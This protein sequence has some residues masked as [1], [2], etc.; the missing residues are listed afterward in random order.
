MLGLGSRFKN[1]GFL[2]P[3]YLLNLAEE[4]IL[5][6]VLYGF[7]KLNKNKFI[8]LIRFDHTK[9]SPEKEIK[10]ICEILKIKNFKIIEVK[11][12]TKGQAD[13][14]RLAFKYCERNDPILIFNIDTIHLGL[15]PVFNFKF[16]GMMETFYA[17]GNHWS[18]AKVN[19][20][21]LIYEVQEKNRISDNC[22]NGLYYFRNYQIFNYCYEN[23]YEKINNSHSLELQ[24]NYIAPMYRILI[25]ENKPI[26][27][28]SV[29]SKMI[30]S[31]GVPSEYFD[32][33]KRFKN[34]LELE[35]L[36]HKY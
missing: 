36:F 29:D 26:Y 34:K 6:F 13:S 18:F 17:E 10:R 4:K 7:R 9:Y 25:D 32:L 15:N 24:E 12:S 28:R 1:A 21:N 2:I 5:Y 11:K 8:F 30:L 22:S 35:S 16:D 27:N 23:L 3:K 33:C 19:S 31:A 14:V 20:K